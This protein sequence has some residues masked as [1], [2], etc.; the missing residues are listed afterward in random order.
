MKTRLSIAAVGLSLIAPAWMG[1]FASGVPTW[2]SP[3]PLLTM[4]PRVI[5]TRGFGGPY[6]P[7]CVVLIPGILFFLWNPG[8]L[9]DPRPALP[10]RTPALLALLT[11]LTAWYVRV[12]WYYGVEYQGMEYTV[13]VSVVNVAWLAVLWLLVLHSMRRPS[14]ANN[15][16]THGVLFVWLGW[17][18]FPYLGELP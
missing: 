18:A 6:L 11:V 7:K 4:A 12:G 14:V 16:L 5:L 15:V 17:Y 13:F 3:F 8:L 10:K 2:Y 1:I 9:L